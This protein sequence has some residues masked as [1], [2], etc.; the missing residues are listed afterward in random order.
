MND[1]LYVLII[2]FKFA[3]SFTDCVAL[4]INAIK[5]KNFRK[6]YLTFLKFTLIRRVLKVT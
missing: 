5:S 1:V 3:I 6:N 2:E 4:K